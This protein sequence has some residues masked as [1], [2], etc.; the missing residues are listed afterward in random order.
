MDWLPIVVLIAV[1]WY[2]AESGITFLLYLAVAGLILFLLTQTS[3]PSSPRERE[4][5]S[6]ETKKDAKA[7]EKPVFGL[8]YS[9][10]NLGRTLYWMFFGSG[11]KK[12]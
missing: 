7:F 11:K 1:A 5:V 3:N 4:E 2:A 12:H 8:G 6:F 10:N 9:L